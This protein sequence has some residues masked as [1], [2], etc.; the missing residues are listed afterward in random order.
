MDGR[1]PAKPSTHDMSKEL[2]LPIIIIIIIIIVIIAIIIITIVV[3]T[4][5]NALLVFISALTR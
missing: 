4:I 2:T 5:I 3:I 1:A